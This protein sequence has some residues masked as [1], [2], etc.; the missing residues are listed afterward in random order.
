MALREIHL[1]LDRNKQPRIKVTLPRDVAFS[2]LN[3]YRSHLTKLEQDYSA[4]IQVIDSIAAKPDEV[5]IDA[6]EIEQGKEGQHQS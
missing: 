6:P 5:I 4:E 1:Y 3:K 2:L